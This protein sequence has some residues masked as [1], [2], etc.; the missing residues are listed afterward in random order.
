LLAEARELITDTMA[1]TEQHPLD[2]DGPVK[3]PPGPGSS[4]GERELAEF[5]GA[6]PSAVAP[7]TAPASAAAVSQLSY[8]SGQ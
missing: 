4:Q 7:A 2:A 1:Q 8:Q 6:T 5:L 3:P